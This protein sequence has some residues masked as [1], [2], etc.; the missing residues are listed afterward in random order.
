MKKHKFYLV[1][2]ICLVLATAVLLI[3]TAYLVP[4]LA[5]AG[6]SKLKKLLVTLRPV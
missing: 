3:V 1:G 5:P 2:R 6:Q 4:T